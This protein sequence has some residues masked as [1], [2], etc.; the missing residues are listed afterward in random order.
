MLQILQWDGPLAAELPSLLVS[1]TY[2]DALCHNLQC[3]PVRTA[4]CTA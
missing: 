4:L 3:N 2:T 1:H